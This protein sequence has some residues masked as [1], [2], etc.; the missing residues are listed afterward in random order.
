M[1][2]SAVLGFDP[3]RQKCG[4]A[5][6]LVDRQILYHQVVQAEEA[7][8]TLQR[9]LEKFPVEVMV[10]GD[11]TSSKQWRQQLEQQLIDSP[12]IIMVDER[13]STLQARD[14]YW[15]MYPP[16]GLGRLVPRQLRT[17]DRPIDD[18]VALL[19]IERY[20]SGTDRRP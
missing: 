18:I 20:L 14:R 2:P 9:L 10:M 4:L 7:I 17:I 6:M 12:P 11:Q 16:Q 19:L 1:Q 15:E 8:A 3:G 5:V 13:Y